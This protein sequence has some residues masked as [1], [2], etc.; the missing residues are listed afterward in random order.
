MQ[1]RGVNTV[2]VNTVG[3][4]TVGVN[5]VGVNAVGIRLRRQI[6][7][8]GLAILRQVR[9]FGDWRNF[10]GRP[11]AVLR[12]GNVQLVVYQWSSALYPGEAGP[13]ERRLGA[14]REGE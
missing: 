4:N 12:S 9:R 8:G 7:S 1:K 14:N 3:V 13:A 6:V 2:G 5:T 10:V 11:D